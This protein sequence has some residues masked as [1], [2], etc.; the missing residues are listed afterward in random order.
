M[1]LA[2]PKGVIHKA[3]SRQQT[4]FGAHSNSSGVGV[5][6]DIRATLATRTNHQ[7]RELLRGLNDEAPES[8][9]RT[10]L[11]LRVM[12][13]VCHQDVPTVAVA[14]SPVLRP[15]NALRTSTWYWYGHREGRQQYIP[16]DE[17]ICQ[18]LEEAFNGG[19]QKSVAV[20]PD[21]HVDLSDSAQ[22]KQRQNKHRY[23]WRA[24]KRSAAIGRIV[25]N[26]SDW[27]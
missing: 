1:A 12:K 21:H 9:R 10:D 6:D 8:E 17:A 18:Q 27:D 3:P 23:R 15:S 16:Y 7:L 20:D 4:A 14:A 24:V 22:F 2:T 26:E 19:D 13:N 11:I 25:V 5:T